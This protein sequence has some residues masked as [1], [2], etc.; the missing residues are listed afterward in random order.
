MYL[1]IVFQTQYLKLREVDREFKKIEIKGEG[2]HHEASAI[3]AKG[4]INIS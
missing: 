4:R 3:T 2:D 1:F